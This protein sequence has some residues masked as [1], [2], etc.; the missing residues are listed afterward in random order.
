MPSNRKPANPCPRPWFNNR[1]AVDLA[2]LLYLAGKSDFLNVII[3]QRSLFTT[4]DALAQSIR[5]VDTNLI[6]LYKALGG[7][8]E[9]APVDPRGQSRGG[10]DQALALKWRLS[11]SQQRPYSGSQVAL[12]NLLIGKALLCLKRYNLRAA[13]SPTWERAYSASLRLCVKPS[14]QAAP[15]AAFLRFWLLSPKNRAKLQFW[16]KI[17]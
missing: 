12:G 17:S 7:G 2:M 10:G 4:E 8:W 1:K 15:S 16:F 6:A 13:L 9:Q 14:F 11:P 3:A 5:T